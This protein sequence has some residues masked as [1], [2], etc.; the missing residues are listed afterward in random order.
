M[1]TQNEPLELH[2]EK[3][4]KFEESIAERT[5]LRRQK[6]DEQLDATDMPDLE[7]EESA[8]QRGNQRGQGLKMLRPNQM[9]RRLPISLAQLKAGNNSEKLRNKN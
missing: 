7:S 3:E 8:A 6:S 2:K 4:P 5:K 1:E 9:L